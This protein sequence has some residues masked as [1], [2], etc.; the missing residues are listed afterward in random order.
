MVLTVGLMMPGSDFTSGGASTFGSLVYDALLDYSKKQEEIHFVFL[1][2]KLPKVHPT[3]FAF[4]RLPSRFATRVS[5][6]HALVISVVKKLLLGKTFDLTSCKSTRLNKLLKKNGVQI[7]WAVQPL[8]LPVNIPYIQT[9]WDVAHRIS[10]HFPE[11]S[12]AE[13]EWSKRERVAHE[14]IGR[15]S[16]VVV[17][18]SRGAYELT[19][20]YGVTSERILIN[21]FPVRR[22]AN[23]ELFASER[24]QNLV[25]YPAQFWPHKNHINLLLGLKLALTETDRKI[26]LVLPGSDKGN[27]KLILNFIEKQGLKEYVDLPG[28]ISAS[29]LADLYQKAGLMIYPSFIGPDNLPP[30]EALSYGCPAAVS[31]IPGSSDIYGDCV[32]YFNP[33]SVYEIANILSNSQPNSQESL[34][35]RNNGFRMALQLDPVRYVEKIIEEIRLVRSESINWDN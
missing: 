25:F 14:V 22:R 3:Q 33:R 2:D 35:L 9:S 17:G 28:F 11:I 1:C 30:L 29:E 34:N 32:K 19:T 7:L 6:I 18:S 26:R 20:A 10:P 16:K 21:P 12:S 15:A 4:V 5:A 13:G 24:D 27:L 8:G 23:Q 31:N